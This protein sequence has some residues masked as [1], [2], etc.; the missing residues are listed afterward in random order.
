M[1]IQDIM[2]RSVISID[3]E[4]DVA[5][6]RERLRN[7][8]INHLV[9]IKGARVVGVL[10][11]KDLAAATDGQRVADV[12]TR[13]VV[14]VAPDVTIRR[15]AGIMRGRGVGSLPVIDGGHLVGIAT[16]SD[17]LTALSKGEVHAAPPRERVVLRKRGPRKHHVPV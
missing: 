1:R 12:M 17:I 11:A 2:S 7:D 8:E 5:T 6:A 13:D 10:S 9:V 15:A 4:I 14:T 3:P 16:T